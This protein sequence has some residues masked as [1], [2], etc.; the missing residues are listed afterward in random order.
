MSF[1]GKIISSS[2]GNSKGGFVS[3]ADAFSDDF[4]SSFG[5]V[6]SFSTD[7]LDAD[8][9]VTSIGAMSFDF[10]SSDCGT[11]PADK[12]AVNRIKKRVISACRRY[13][14]LIKKSTIPVPKRK[15]Q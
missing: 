12:S 2:V 3:I 9:F 8:E 7:S 15:K 14:V 6:A 5:V 11:F 13:H 4:E 10:G 1:L